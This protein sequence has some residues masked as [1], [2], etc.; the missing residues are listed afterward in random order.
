MD[1]IRIKW[2][3]IPNVTAPTPSIYRY[4]WKPTDPQPQAPNWDNGYTT[5]VGT[6]QADATVVTTADRSPTRRQRPGKPECRDPIKLEPLALAPPLA[7][8]LRSLGPSASRKS[9]LTPSAEYPG[10]FECTMSE[11]GVI[12]VGLPHKV[13]TSSFI[14]IPGRPIRLS[15][16]AFPDAEGRLEILAGAVQDVLGFWDAGRSMYDWLGPGPTL[17]LAG[18]GPDTWPGALGKQPETCV[19]KE[20][21]DPMLL[22]EFVHAVLAQFMEWWNREVA[23]RRKAGP[24]ATLGPD[25]L[26]LDQIR[27]IALRRQRIALGVYEWL[28]QLEVVVD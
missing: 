2:L 11:Q 24:Q 18:L 8:A 12:V 6:E 10:F 25:T 16:V 14:M 22:Y 27:L 21:G 28:P 19:K 26:D 9:T 1:K 5:H 17:R 7:K 20:G 15:D 23:L 13:D 4:R 3:D